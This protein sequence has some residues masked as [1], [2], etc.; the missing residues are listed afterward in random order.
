MKKAI[1]FPVVSLMA[2]PLYAQGLPAPIVYGHVNKEIHYVDQKKE[3][4]YS[5]VSNIVDVQNA[6]T[7]L[8]ARGLIPVNENIQTTYNIMLGLDSSNNSTSGG[9][10]AG[11]IR[12][13]NADLSFITPYGTIFGGQV[14][15]ITTVPGIFLDPLITTGVGSA[16]VDTGAYIKNAAS[17]S[18]GY[19][20]RGRPDQIG[21]KTPEWKGL[22]YSTAVYKLAVL[23]NPATSGL[24][25]LGNDDDLVDDNTISTTTFS[26]LSTA[27]RPATRWNNLV[28]FKHKL[29]DQLS[30]FAN[31]A[32]SK[33]SSRVFDT[34]RDYYLLGSVTYGEFT[35]AGQYTNL[36]KEYNGAFTG[37]DASK[38]TKE[39]DMYQASLKWTRS[40]HTLATTYA[41]KSI[42]GPSK[43]ATWTTNSDLGQYTQY[44]VGYL[45]Q[46]HKNVNLRAS[47]AHYIVK[48]DK[49]AKTANWENTANMLSLGTFLTF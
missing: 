40:N 6:E 25:N 43:D 41:H 4:G 29:N 36:K 21:Y 28:G 45:Y 32:Y 14:A 2:S 31:A 23:T 37:G 22:Q 10:G 11:R 24:Y 20:E 35:L 47:Y 27:H 13:R 46:I 38:K 12:L 7:R 3:M 30:F 9:A 49:M 39:N 44:A 1:L 15:E 42:S 5:K 26:G 18:L 16:G 8:G 48:T 33:L 19:L 34:Y 17:I